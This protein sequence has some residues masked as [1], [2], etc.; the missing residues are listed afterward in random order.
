[1][2]KDKDDEKSSNV[3]GND[4]KNISQR[5]IAEKQLIKQ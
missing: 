4:N 5:G 3:D 1:L 2:N